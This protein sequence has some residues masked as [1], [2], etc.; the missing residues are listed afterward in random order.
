MS[1]VSIF[2][3]TYTK[4]NLEDM[5]DKFPACRHDVHLF[6]RVFLKE[7]LTWFS[8]MDEIRQNELVDAVFDFHSK[9]RTRRLSNQRDEEAK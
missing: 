5:L 1:Q 3:E 7:K 4:V 9:D 8:A 6:A 2:G